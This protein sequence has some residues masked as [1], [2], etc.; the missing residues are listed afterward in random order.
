[1][2][3]FHDLIPA[4]MQNVRPGNVF[5]LGFKAIEFEINH[6]CNRACAYC[7]NSIAERKSKG[8]MPEGLFVKVLSELKELSYQ[9][10]VSFHFYNEPLL[11][12]DLDH[13]TT[14]TKSYLPRSRIEIFTNGTLLTEERFRTLVDLGVD[15][16]T[17]TKHHGEAELPLDSFYENLSEALKAHVKRQTFKELVYTSRGGLMKVGYTKKIPPLDLPCFIPSSV[18]VVTKDGNILPCFEDYFEKNRM[19]NVTENS[20]VEIWN[21]EPYRDFRERLK[22]RKRQE[23]PVC[24]KCNCILIIP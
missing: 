12:P 8:R 22:K 21:S 4:M 6:D 3:M 17:V 7:P 2:L 9:G 23:F 1:M 10:R 24:D 19:G 14:L 13:F 15:K 18:L 16:F 5:P 11:S 20:L